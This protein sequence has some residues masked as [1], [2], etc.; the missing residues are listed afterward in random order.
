M[1][2]IQKLNNFINDAGDL[3]DRQHALISGLQLV[4]ERLLVVLLK[5][6]LVIDQLEAKVLLALLAYLV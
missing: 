6:V 1:S 2:C 3:E 4:V 5:A